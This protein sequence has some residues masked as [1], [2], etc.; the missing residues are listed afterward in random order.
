M[1]RGLAVAWWPRP[2]LNTEV[3]GT[4][5]L[6]GIQSPEPVGPWNHRHQCMALGRFLGEDFI[7]SDKLEG[8]R[9]MP[10]GDKDTELRAIDAVIGSNGLKDD[11][12]VPTEHADLYAE[13]APE[14]SAI[15]GS[16]AVATAAE[17]YEQF[18]TKAGE[19]QTRFKT[20]ANRANVL[21]LGT[22]FCGAIVVTAGVLRDILGLEAAQALAIGFAIAALVV[23]AGASAYLYGAKGGDYLTK[24]MRSRAEAEAWRTRYFEAVTAPDDADGQPYPTGLLLLKLQYFVR[25]Q[26]NVQLLY[27]DKRGTEH[28]RSAARSLR[29]AAF[30][31]ALSAIITGL[32]GMLST[33]YL[34]FVALGGI[35][36]IASALTAF[37][38]TRESINQDQRNAERYERTFETLTKLKMNLGAIQRGIIKAGP[39]PLTDFVQAVHEQIFL[40]HRQWLDDAALAS[41]ALQ[42][43]EETL[44]N[45]QTAPLSPVVPENRPKRTSQSVDV[46]AIAS[47]AQRKDT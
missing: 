1:L 22:A 11:A 45:V 2:R 33:A 15:L 8:N 13:S 12:I 7:S 40:E 24:W 31:I 37:A 5:T 28:E 23:G 9:D 17:S 21:V 36:V 4:R 27:Y 25:Y 42:T 44:K 30:A 47:D 41:T 34:E 16:T 35:G 29:F 20:A 6:V 14:L 43:L 26:L 19:R 3:N 32:A 46:T 39:K 18:D 10:I 38:S